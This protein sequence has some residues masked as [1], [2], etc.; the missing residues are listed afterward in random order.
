MLQWGGRSSPNQVQGILGMLLV[1]RGWIWGYWG[2][3]AWWSDTGCCRGQ[4]VKLGGYEVL[5]DMGVTTA[6]P[7]TYGVSGCC[8]LTPLAMGVQGAAK[9]QKVTHQIQSIRAVWGTQ[10]QSPWPWSVGILRGTQIQLHCL[11]AVEI[12]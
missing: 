4:E 10:I 7:A 6:D 2:V 8:G 12:L 1:G 3:T 11:L 5:G 9:Q